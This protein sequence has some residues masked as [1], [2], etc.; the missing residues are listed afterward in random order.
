RLTDPVTLYA[1]YGEGFRANI[2]TDVNGAIFDPETSIS[3]EIGAKLT[4]FDGRL[5]GTLALF[6]LDKSN[7][8]ASDT[9]NPG[10]SVAIGRARSRG[11]ELD[12]NGRLPGGVEMLLSYAYVDAEARSTL[13]EPNFNFQIRPGDPLVNIPDHNLNLQAAKRFELG[14]RSAQVGGGVQYVGERSGETGTA[15]TLPSHTLFRVFGDVTLLDGVTL[16][17]SIQNLFDEHW[18]A[19][20]YSPLWVQPG[21]PR[22]ATIG[23]RASF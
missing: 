20:S 23:L 14:G 17:G 12:L 2:G 8:L 11:V 7:V 1:A 16:F 5:N 4:L 10:F 9:G 21:A 18:Y 15:F 19:N 13:L 22:T 3:K 6:Q